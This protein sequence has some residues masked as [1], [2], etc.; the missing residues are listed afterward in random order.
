MKIFLA[1]ASFL[2]ICCLIAVTH[3]P[4]LTGAHKINPCTANAGDCYSIQGQSPDS[5]CDGVAKHS[6]MYVYGDD[7]TPF[8]LECVALA[9]IGGWLPLDGHAADE[10]D[11]EEPGQ[12]SRMA[13]TESVWVIQMPEQEAFAAKV[14]RVTDGVPVVCYRFKDNNALDCFYRNIHTGEVVQRH[15]ISNTLGV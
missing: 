9:G 10:N 15:V 2:A 1:I 7:G 4:V 12:L 11:E 14:P 3:Q 13:K 8:F 6:P 5:H